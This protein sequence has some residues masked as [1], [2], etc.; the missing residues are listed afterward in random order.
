MQHRPWG[1]RHAL[2]V[3][4]RD[5]LAEDVHELYV[6]RSFYSFHAEWWSRDRPLYLYEEATQ[7]A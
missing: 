2:A 7:A 4:V 5:N 3:L 6:D 1:R